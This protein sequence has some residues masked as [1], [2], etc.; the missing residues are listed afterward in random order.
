MKHASGIATS[1]GVPPKRRNAPPPNWR[2]SGSRGKNLRCG[3]SSR[4][5]PGRQRVLAPRPLVAPGARLILARLA[6]LLAL[7]PS[8]IEDAQSNRTRNAAANPIKS[9]IKKVLGLG[10]VALV[11]RLIVLCQQ[12]GARAGPFDQRAGGWNSRL[13]M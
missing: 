4:R 6:G 9:R 11:S 12:G 3:V 8:P 7:D 10:D 5:N 2:G 1:G 13:M